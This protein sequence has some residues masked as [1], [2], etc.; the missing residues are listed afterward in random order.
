MAL[1]QFHTVSLAAVAQTPEQRSDADEV[2]PRVVRTKIPINFVRA[3]KMAAI[4]AGL[5]KA[6]AL[7]GLLSVEHHTSDNAL[8]V[9]ATD[10]A[11]RE[12]KEYIRLRDVAPG[13]VRIRLDVVAAE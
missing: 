11:V 10:D 4:V 7:P 8:I 12:A 2:V 3:D 1:V 5:M 9:I 13:I 6:G